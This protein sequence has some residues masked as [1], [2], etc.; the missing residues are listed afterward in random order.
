[1][2]ARSA[3]EKNSME[4]QHSGGILGGGETFV[5]DPIPAPTT[6]TTCPV[7]TTA[8]PSQPPTGVL[9][10]SAWMQV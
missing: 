3:G 10:S 8:N 7:E 4:E 5:D 9:L 1:M 2:N 6:P